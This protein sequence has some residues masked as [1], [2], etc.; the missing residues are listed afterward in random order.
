[1]RPVGAPGLQ[2]SKRVTC[3]PG[4]LTRRSVGNQLRLLL[5][6]Y[7]DKSPD[8]KKLRQVGALQNGALQNYLGR[9]SIS[10]TT[11]REGSWMHSNAQSAMSSAFI[12]RARAAA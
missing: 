10:S 11:T 2:P 8:P 3:R 6:T 9:T 12:M 5:N 1:L 7:G 4:A